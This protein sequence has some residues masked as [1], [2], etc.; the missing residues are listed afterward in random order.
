[1]NFR[2]FD[3]GGQ[4]SERKKW[5]HCFDEVKA[6]IF[7]TSLSDF[8]LMLCEDRTI[9]RMSESMRLFASICNNRWFQETCMILFLNKI[10]VFE[11]KITDPEGTPL[12]VCFLSSTATVRY[13]TKLWRLECGYAFSLRIHPAATAAESAV[14]RKRGVGTATAAATTASQ[15]GFEQSKCGWGWDPAPGFGQTETH[16]QDISYPF[17]PSAGSAAPVRLSKQRPLQKD[18]RLFVRQPKTDGKNHEL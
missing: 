8:D 6:I 3:V 12:T 15:H 4:R 7:V 14:W 2:L 10:D 11:A 17:K 16:R 9:N 18:L 5:I 1:M 13:G